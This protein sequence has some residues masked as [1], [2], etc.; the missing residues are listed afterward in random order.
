MSGFERE[1]PHTRGA[2]SAG[3]RPVDL[4]ERIRLLERRLRAASF[5]QFDID[6]RQALEELLETL[7]GLITDTAP[8]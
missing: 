3:L 4:T 7:R 1:P 8:D 6:E 5:E 2:R